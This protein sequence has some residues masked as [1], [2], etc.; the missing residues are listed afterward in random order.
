MQIYNNSTWLLSTMEKDS[1]T[2]WRLTHCPCICDIYNQYTWASG[3]LLSYNVA[4]R[5]DDLIT[6]EDHDA[7]FDGRAQALDYAGLVALRH[8]SSQR[9]TAVT[10]KMSTCGPEDK[11]AATAVKPLEQLRGH[12]EHAAFLT[13]RNSVIYPEYIDKINEYRRSL[14]KSDTPLADTDEDKKRKRTK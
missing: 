5:V 3:L 1:L 12:S 7:T 10:A 14:N 6:A 8:M 4:L 2:A 13:T 9:S 11:V